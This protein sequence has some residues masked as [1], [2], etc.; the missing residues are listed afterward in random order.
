M[1]SVLLFSLPIALAAV[2]FSGYRRRARRQHDLHIMR[3]RIMF[4]I[5]SGY[6]SE[7]EKDQRQRQDP[8]GVVIHKNGISR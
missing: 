7:A 5:S 6:M 3:N 4:G 2:V 1:H 8:R